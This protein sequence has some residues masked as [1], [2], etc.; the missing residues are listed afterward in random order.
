LI[1]QS[2]RLLLITLASISVSA[3]VS[4]AVLYL[5]SLVIV[6]EAITPP[7]VMCLLIAMSIDYS[8]F[9]LTRFREELIEAGFE[10]PIDPEHFPDKHARYNECIIKTMETS[11]ATISI[12]GII[13][14]V[15]FVFLALFPVNLI[16]SMGL[17]CAIT[18]VVMMSVNLT[19]APAI[20][21]SC[22]RFFSTSACRDRAGAKFWKKV[23]RREKGP[24]MTPRTVGARQVDE[25]KGCHSKIGVLATTFPYNWGLLLLTVVVVGA[26]SYPI[27]SL[28]ITNDL[29]QDV[30]YGSRLFDVIVR[31]LERFGGGVTMPFN[32]LVM[33]AKGYESEMHVFSSKFFQESAACF[34]KVHKE[35]ELA[36]PVEEYGSNTFLYLSYMAPSPGLKFTI[37]WLSMQWFCFPTFSNGF[38][39]PGAGMCGGLMSFL[40]NTDDYLT[41]EPTATSAMIVTELDPMGKD[42][43]KYLDTLVGLFEEYGAQHHLEIHVGGTPAYAIDMVRVVFQMFPYMIAA[44]L[45]VAFAFLGFTF[46]S[47]VIPARAIVVNLFCLGM[48]Y[49]L[50][51]LVYQYGMLNWM[52][53]FAVSG[54][55]E[56][57]PW[58][59]P[60]VVFFVLTGISLDYDV[61]LCVRVT[62]YRNDGVEPIQAIRSGLESVGGIIASAGLV[63]V[64]AF[65]AL[66]FSSIQQLNMLGFMMV[67]SVIFCT[68]VTCTIINPSILSILGHYNWW[69]SELSKQPVVND[70]VNDMGQSLQPT[71]D[72]PPPTV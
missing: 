67:V 22:P 53:W 57:L 50:S 11:G 19:L 61:F 17:G 28:E 24:Q 66:M 68:M 21:A 29:K 42:G 46:R 58:L 32:V 12:S 69:P 44:T 31:L 30:A 8:L 6:V 55:L 35:L 72:Q 43:Q 18:M 41:E 34:K 51:I 13:L 64:V 40:T 36:M 60:V 39:A 59:V 26:L 62:E 7:L 5:L 65:G 70:V 4:C 20:L 27:L 23:C 14:A 63:M 38:V 45:A 2:A 15:A 33:P 48:T 10:E 25:K 16:A 56:A 52:G 49:G 71:S 37:P 3:I 9:L 54:E 47:V 1:V